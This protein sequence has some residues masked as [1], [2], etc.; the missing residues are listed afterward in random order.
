MV[1]AIMIA[2]GALC[3]AGVSVYKYFKL[4]PVDTYADGGTDTFYPQKYYPTQEKYQV[5]INKTW[6]TRYK[7]VYIVQYRSA[8]KLTYTQNM[9]TSEISAQEILKKKAAVERRI[10]WI[11]GTKKYITIPAD[12]TAESYVNQYRTRCIMFFSVSILYLAAFSFFLFKR[13]KISRIED[14]S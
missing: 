11:N 13:W 1:I 12:Q 10:L 8:K 4:A 6:Q 3:T 2:V 9:G 14:I 7:T 5:K